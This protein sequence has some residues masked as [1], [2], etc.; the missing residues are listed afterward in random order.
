MAMGIYD[1]LVDTGLGML[2]G[3][4]QN[5]WNTEAANTANANAEKLLDKQNEFNALEI[6]K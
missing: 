5:K 3:W 1:P 4:L 2:G 6:Q